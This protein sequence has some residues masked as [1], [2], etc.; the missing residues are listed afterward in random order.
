LDLNDQRPAFF[1]FNRGDR[2]G[3]SARWRG[4]GCAQLSSLVQLSNLFG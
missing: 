2:V 3:I 1:A 4:K